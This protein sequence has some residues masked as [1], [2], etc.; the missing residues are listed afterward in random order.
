MPVRFHLRV[1][2]RFYAPLEDVWR[3]KTDVDQL[4]NEL[5]PWL[6]ATLNKDDLQAGLR[7]EGIPR[8]L[9]VRFWGL[10]VVPFPDWPLELV[11]YE[12]NRIFVDTT[13]ENP[14]FHEWEHRHNIEEASDAVRYWDAITFSPK[15]GPPHL[16][17]RSIERLFRHRHRK[18]AAMFETDARATAISQLRVMF[19][20]EESGEGFM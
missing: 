11:K 5:H 16:V 9:P 14:L 8:S 17:A 20:V 18:T 15:W 3:A 2:T 7:G 6:R 1:S 13:R 19:D 10:G 12:H 4:E